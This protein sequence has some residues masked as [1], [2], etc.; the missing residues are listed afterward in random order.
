MGLEFCYTFVSYLR[1]KVSLRKYSFTKLIFMLPV[2]A[3]LLA[4]HSITQ[5][6]ISSETENPTIVSNKVVKSNT[7]ATFIAFDLEDND[8][9]FNES[10]PSEFEIELDF[11]HDYSF[12]DNFL[13]LQL[14]SEKQI[15]TYGFHKTNQKLPLYDLFCNWKF[16]LT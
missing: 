14:E 1:I 13:G 12:S 10:E 6:L 8:L 5:N 9:L 16:H 11:F 2:F 4:L 7:N 3:L 15:I